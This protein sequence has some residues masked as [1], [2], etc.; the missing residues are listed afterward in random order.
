[1]ITANKIIGVLRLDSDVPHSYTP[2]DLRFLDIISG[3]AAVAIKNSMLYR[4]TEEL[5]IH[6]SL[7]GLYVQRYFKQ[8]LE[9]ETKRATRLRK[10]LSLRMPSAASGPKCC[11]TISLGMPAWSRS[12]R[13]SGPRSA[14]CTRC[15]TS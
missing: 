3:L 4:Q 14:P 2:D 7:T 15:D 12:T 5:A 13:A 9:E 10:P 11:S 1:M 6:D 8:R